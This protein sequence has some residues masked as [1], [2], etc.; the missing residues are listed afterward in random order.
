[1]FQAIVCLPRV[2]VCLFMCIVVVMVTGCARVCDCYVCV[3]VCARVYICANY[4][5]DAACAPFMIL[6][7][8]EGDKRGIASGVYD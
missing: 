2:G 7:H 8:A 3:R 1:M 6:R 5:I 4:V